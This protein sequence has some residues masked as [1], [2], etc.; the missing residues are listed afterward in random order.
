MNIQ[1]IDAYLLTHGP[2]LGPWDEESTKRA[3]LVSVGPQLVPLLIDRTCAQLREFADGMDTAPLG[4]MNEEAVK[5]A[6]SRAAKLIADMLKSATPPNN[7]LITTHLLHALEDQADAGKRSV[8]ALMCSV[9]G[10]SASSV[11]MAVHP[12]L[13]HFDY[14]VKIVQLC[15]SLSVALYQTS[16]S[17]A[18]L[19]RARSMIEDF[20]QH[21]PVLARNYRGKAEG[22]TLLYYDNLLLYFLPVV[23]SLTCY[24]STPQSL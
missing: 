23:I 17:R 18:Q 12:V 13:K 14:D 11:A 4:W 3:Q 15:C 24:A 6:H 19:T 10:A 8:G 21:S 1:E 2:D 22:N 5:Q 9:G 16:A 20:I 7:E